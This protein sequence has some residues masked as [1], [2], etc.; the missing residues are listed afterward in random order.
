MQ[1]GGRKISATIN[2]DGRWQY[3]V[4]QH[5][6]GEYDPEQLHYSHA[7]DGRWMHGSD[8]GPWN[9]TSV[10]GPW[11]LTEDLQSATVWFRRRFEAQPGVGRD[12]VTFDGVNYTSDFWLNGHYL[13]SHEGYLGRIRLDVTGLI[14]GGIYL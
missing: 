10:P 1:I 3:R 7:D 14:G 8:A 4:D 5:D 13:G 11:P 6:V 2:L 9:E 12:V